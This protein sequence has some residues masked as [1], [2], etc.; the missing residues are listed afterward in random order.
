MENQIHL[1]TLRRSSQICFVKREG[2]LD[3][4]LTLWSKMEDSG[5]L[6]NVITFEIIISALFKKDETEKAEKF[7]HEMISRELLK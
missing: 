1:K 4:A 2:L 7:L 3:E 5:C 6:S